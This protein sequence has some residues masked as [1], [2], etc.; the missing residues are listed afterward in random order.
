MIRQKTKLR[1]PTF[2]L[3]AALLLASLLVACG[4]GAGESETLKVGFI[5]P[6]TGEYSVWGEDHLAAAQ[7]TVD[8]WNEKGG[9]LGRQIELVVG[10]SQADGTQAAAIAN[11]FVDQGIQ[12]VIPTF[13][14]EAEA[15]IPILQPNKVISIT[16]LGDLM[17]EGGTEGYY[18]TTMREDVSAKFAAR[19]TVEYLEGEQIAIIDD[20]RVDNVTTSTLL[21]QR[22][23]ELGVEPVYSG[24]IS[25]GQQNYTPTL[26]QVESLNP[27]V[28]F[29]SV[30]N[31][32]AGLLRRQGEELGIEATWIVSAG[33]AEALF[34]EI[35]GD[36]GVPT[37][38]YGSTRV[39]DRFEAFAAN[40]EEANDRPPGNYNDYTY[41][42]AN[43]LF[44]AIENAGSMEYEA[45]K[46]ALEDLENFPGV[47]GPIF[48]D[49]T[50][51]RSTEK[52]QVVMFGEGLEWQEVED[53]PFDTPE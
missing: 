35:A 20:G 3:I 37:Y 1:S 34:G 53:V 36:S 45:V 15:M 26:T 10:D 48:F 41:D 13:S 11:Q 22:L 50:G 52:Y 31:P 18:R 40:Y 4:G 9:V 19:L 32:E 17:A 44:T 43:V 33:A 24:S 8:E 27:D 25:A 2:L 12:F 30:S 38:S 39:E 42:A 7:L 29:L 46:Q 21:T 28:I 23:Q 16:G 51:S 14:V 6:M 49:D 47:T 5:G